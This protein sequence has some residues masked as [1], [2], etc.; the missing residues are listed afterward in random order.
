MEQIFLCL[1]AMGFTGAYVA[2]KRK[3]NPVLWFFVC[4]FFGLIAL[5]TLIFLPLFLKKKPVVPV[6]APAPILPF[7]AETIWYY[8]DDEDRQNGPMSFL[9]LQEIKH[10]GILR[11]D[12]YIWNETLSHWKQWKDMFPSFEG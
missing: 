8:L 10:K 4:F 6:K 3:L 5:I 11:E 2:K 7:A 9:K 12:T 1:I